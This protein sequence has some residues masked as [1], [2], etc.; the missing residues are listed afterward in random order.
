MQASRYS[1]KPV[2]GSAPVPVPVT[3]VFGVA[4]VLAG[5]LSGCRGAT[6]SSSAA[7]TTAPGPHARTAPRSRPT[8]SC[9][10]AELSVKPSSRTTK[11]GLDIARFTVTAGGAD[12]C[13]LAGAPNL[14]PKGILSQQVPGATVDLAVSQLPLPDDVDLQAGD[15]AAVPLLPGGSAS[16]YL[17][18]YSTSPIVCVQSNGFGFNA[19]GD[20]SYSDMKPVDYAIGSVC[21]GIFYVSAV[22][23]RA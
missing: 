5:I 20:T 1:K 22:F 18:W 21:D 11:Q 10:T 16:F 4:I 6:G 8:R 3:F 9:S 7:T 23:Q 2:S 17:A 19:P 13:V 14:R 15:G 12:G